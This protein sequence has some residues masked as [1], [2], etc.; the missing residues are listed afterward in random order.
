MKYKIGDRIIW[1][2]EKDISIVQDIAKD[3]YLLLHDD[4]SE[5]WMGI[6]WVEK[7]TVSYMQNKNHPHT[8]IFK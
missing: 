2:D 7:R 4:N 5:G 8:S 3:A 1:L 6:N